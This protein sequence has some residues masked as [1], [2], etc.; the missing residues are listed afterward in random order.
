MKGQKG[1]VCG[2]GD[3]KLVGRRD[4]SVGCSK[5]LGRPEG[6]RRGDAEMSL[7]NDGDENDEERD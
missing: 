7:V 5:I 1:K 6:R 4:N 2:G 3:K